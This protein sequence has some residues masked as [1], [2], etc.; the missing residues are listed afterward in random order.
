M[1]LLRDGAKHAVVDAYV[2]QDRQA[3][4]RLPV[5]AG[6]KHKDFCH[7]HTYVQTDYENT[8]L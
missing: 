3:V 6:L 7:A 1:A 2:Q 5:A 8:H 4:R